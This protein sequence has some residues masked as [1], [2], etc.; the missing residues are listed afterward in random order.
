MDVFVQWILAFFWIFKAFVQAAQCRSHCCSIS[1]GNTY[2]RSGALRS[3]GLM[4]HGRGKADSHC[5]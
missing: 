2:R 5:L 3:S 1:G 4:C